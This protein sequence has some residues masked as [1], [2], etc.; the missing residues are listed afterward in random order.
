M[1]GTPGWKMFTGPGIQ[2]YQG[3]KKILK[4]LSKGDIGHKV[5]VLPVHM[6]FM[7]IVQPTPGVVYP[8]PQT[9]YAGSRNTS[10]GE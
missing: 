9:R 7:R 8:A 1:E 10:P 2:T 5:P 3:R 6:P 4:V